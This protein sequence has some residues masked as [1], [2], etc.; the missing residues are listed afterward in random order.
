[1]TEGNVSVGTVEH[2]LCALALCGI[3]N[4]SI[5]IDGDEVPILDGSAIPFV[6]LLSEAGRRSQSA[7]KRVLKIER[8]VEVSLDNK[9]ARLTPCDRFVAELHI[10]F[11]HPAIASSRQSLTLDQNQHSF[12]QELARAR[13]F[14]FI[15]DIDLLRSKGLCRGGSIDNAIV[16]ND[17][18]VI[19]T[20][21]LRYED[22]FVRHKMLD[23]IGDLYVEG[24]MIEGYF[25]AER[26]GHGLNNLLM[27]ELLSSMDNYSIQV[28]DN[29]KP[30]EDGLIALPLALGF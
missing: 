4:V 3:D 30:S 28:L 21:G 16:L 14:G 17:A 15:R 23:V 12:V 8:T 6:Y 18:V 9:V 5:D 26:T 11:S 1:M 2:L 22:E 7:P 20:D 19:N 27:R 25:Y 13:T 24:M 10:D 29:K